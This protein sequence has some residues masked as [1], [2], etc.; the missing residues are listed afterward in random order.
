MKAD[1]LTYRR[2]TGTAILGLA[3]QAG[4][5]VLLFIYAYVSRDHAA[6]TATI[7][8]AIGIPAWI[9]LVVLFDQHRRERVEAFEAESLDLSELSSSSVFDESGDELKVAARRL[10]TMYRFF[11]PA[12]GILVAA[13]LIGGGLLRLGSARAMMSDTG[14]PD[15][16]AGFFA[17]G[18]GVAIAVVG[19]IFARFVSGM[20]KQ[21]V[22]SQLSAGAAFAVGSSLMGLA[23]AIGHFVDI[24]G[25]D[26]MLVILHTALPVAMIVLGAE[27]VLS[28][29]L[30]I[31]RPRVSGEVARLAFDSRVLG[32]VAAPDTVAQSI[33][34]AINYQLGSEVSSSWF[35]KLLSRWVVILVAIGVLVGWG[36]T[37]IM[38]VEPHQRGILLQFGRVAKADVPSGLV[39]KKPWPMQQLVVPEFVERDARGRIIN[40]VRTATGVRSVDLGTAPPVRSG[41]ILWTNDHAENEWFT[42][43]QTGDRMLDAETGEGGSDLARDF[44]IIAIEVPLHYVVSDPLAYESFAPVEMRDRIL[45]AVG[46]RAV[47]TTM[48]SMTVE[49]ILGEARGELPDRLRQAVQEAYASLNPDENGEPRGVGIEVLYVGAAGIH[50]PKETARAFEN[51][52]TAEQKRQAQL[53]DAQQER[54]T[55]LTE[56]AGGVELA[57]EALQLLAVRDQLRQDDAPAEEIAMATDELEGVLE[58]GVGRASRLLGTARAQRWTRHMRERAR[59]SRYAGQKE[60]YRAAPTLYRAQ[61]YLD[62]IS[63]IMKDTRVFVLSE[64]LDLRLRANL[65]DERSAQDVFNPQV[66]GEF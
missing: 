38:V 56:A 29:L 63:E 32:F 53:E 40:V 50:P 51:V 48:S 18:V 41:P 8:A 14:L 25:P 19:F 62:A 39:F 5:A 66:E 64:D 42:I 22:W 21:K 45:R 57:E 12:A 44:A 1:F 9:V 55:T 33:G 11:V 26:T 4:L 23:I 61:L 15:E 10:K 7:Y 3:I 13:L 30:E 43:V 24:A 27:A 49:Q 52:V 46:E 59:A 35:Y 37:S 47:M 54:I 34:E 36:L 2:A 60:A 28:F 6:M 31:Y 20:A 17:I 65:E 16:R 58:A